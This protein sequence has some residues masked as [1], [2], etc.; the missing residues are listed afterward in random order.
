MGSARRTARLTAIR[1]LL[2]GLAASTD[3]LPLAETIAMVPP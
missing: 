3:V 2:L 1:A